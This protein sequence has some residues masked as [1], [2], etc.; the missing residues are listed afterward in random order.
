DEGS[1]V[2]Y[3]SPILSMQTEREGSN[4]TVIV[5]GGFTR[6][7]GTS[8]NGYGRIGT[9]NF[10]VVEDV[11][12]F[13]SDTEE[14]IT[15]GGVDAE[16]LTGEG[17]LNSVHVEPFEITILNNPEPVQPLDTEI[18]EYLDE[19]LLA[20]P[21]PTGNNLIVHLNGQRE[22]SALSLVDMTGRT[23]LRRDGLHTNHQNLD[24]SQLPI[25]IY[26]LSVTTEEGVVN[27]KIEVIR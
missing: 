13:R 4:G 3:D 6:T 21:N 11:N 10:V 14:T 23:V 26:T 8:T 9:V 19:K 7:S 2:S 20:F 22:F 1:W 25:G 5:E 15:L 17:H 12:G 24:L 27:R 18:D 16:V